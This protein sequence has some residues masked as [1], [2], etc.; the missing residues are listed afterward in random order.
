MNQSEQ[1]ESVVRAFVVLRKRERMLSL[2]A[3]P[4]R[5]RQALNELYHFGDLD[6]RFVVPVE[7]RRQTPE[8]IAEALQSYGAPNKC[9][10]ISTDDSLDGREMLL[11]EVLAAIVW[12]W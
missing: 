2:L 11:D 1:E 10:V 4:K 8:G 7:P 5:R 9:W 3:N 12:K 6:D